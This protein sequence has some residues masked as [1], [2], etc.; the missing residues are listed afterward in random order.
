MADV[1]RSTTTDTQETSLNCYKYLRD[2]NL[3]YDEK[4]TKLFIEDDVSL[5]RDGIL[6]DD[7][8]P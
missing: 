7:R 8:L 2:E 6:C 5:V 1:R 3:L 4:I